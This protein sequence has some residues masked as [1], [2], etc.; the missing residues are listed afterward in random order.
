[1][2]VNASQL[3]ATASAVVGITAAATTVW[4]YTLGRRLSARKEAALATAATAAAA[5][6]ESTVQRIVT[7]AVADV[8]VDMIARVDQSD[9][10]TAEKLAEV[11]AK[12]ETVDI[13]AQRT[14]IS[15]ATQFG[16]NGGGIRQAIN[17]LGT[18][19][20]NLDGRFRQHLLEGGQ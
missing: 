12:L 10:A 15:L 5:E 3:I 16:G 11:K 19:V 17:E 8:K 13:R 6:L 7:T 2:S 18:T 4:W 1:M 14:E 20:A 9:T